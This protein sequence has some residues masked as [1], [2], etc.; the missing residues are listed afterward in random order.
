MSISKKPF[1]PNEKMRRKIK[2]SIDEK[3]LKLNEK[4]RRKTNHLLLLQKMK[5]FQNLNKKMK[6]KTKY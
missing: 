4:M 1:T 2:G 5:N 3:S 6:K